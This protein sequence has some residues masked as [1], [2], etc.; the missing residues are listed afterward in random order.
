MYLSINRDK[1]IFID[2]SKVCSIAL[3]T[4]TRQQ[5]DPVDMPDNL[6]CGPVIVFDLG[7]KSYITSDV[8]VSEAVAKSTIGT[9]INMQFG[10]GVAQATIDTFDSEDDAAILTEGETS[11]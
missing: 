6:L 1:T 2:L 11:Q 8:F 3:M 4:R 9:L 10:K 7:S 5:S